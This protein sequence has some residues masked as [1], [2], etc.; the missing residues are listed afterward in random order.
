VT[1]TEPHC[2]RGVQPGGGIYVCVVQRWPTPGSGLRPGRRRFQRKLPLWPGVC[3][4]QELYR[5]DTEPGRLVWVTFAIVT[6]VQWNAV[7]EGALLD[8]VFVC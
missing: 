5:S 4:E 3:I 7:F 1:N 6:L 8:V 2:S